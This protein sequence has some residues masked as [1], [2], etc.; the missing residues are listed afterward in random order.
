MEGAY[1]KGKYCPAGQGQVPGPR[2]H[3]EDHGE[4]PRPEGAARR[5][6]RLAHDLAPMRKDFARYVELANKGARE[7]GFADTGAMW[8]S[9]YDM[10]P[11]RFRERAR[12]AL[13]A[14]QAALRLAPRLRALEAAREVRRR[15][16]R[17]R[18]DP[19]APARQ[20]VGAGA[21]TTS[22]RSSA[23]KDADPGF[24]LTEI[25]KSRQDGRRSRWSGTA[26][27]SSRRS[28]SIRCPKTFWDRSLFTKPRDRE[29]VCHASA[30]DVDNVNDLRHQD[31]HRHHGRGLHDDPPRARPQLLPARLQHAALSV[32]RQRQRRL[33]RGGR[34][35][36]SRSRSRRSTW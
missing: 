20:H 10:P 3:H 11:G 8:R 25:L 4:Q 16:A 5:L 35:T 1:G 34:A 30:W 2:G 26:R 22:I 12:P 33:P 18:P 6:A 14:G 28:A 24:D 17:D 21:G 32:P 15:G 36:R 7:L 23:P 27:G 13:G 9:K 31:V 29:V 19:G